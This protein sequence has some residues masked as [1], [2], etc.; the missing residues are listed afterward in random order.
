MA[1]DGK[2]HWPTMPGN[3]TPGHPQIIGSDAFP[4]PGMMDAPGGVPSLGRPSDGMLQTYLRG[5]F[6][7][8]GLPVPYAPAEFSPEKA[9]ANPLYSVPG[10]LAQQRL[11]Y[12]H[13]GAMT[14]PWLNPVVAG[15]VAR[16]EI[17]T[18][19]FD[20]RPELRGSGNNAPTTVIPIFRGPAFGAGGRLLFQIGRLDGGSIQD[21]GV[22]IE[23]YSIEGLHISDD[24]QVVPVTQPQ[25]ITPDFWAGATGVMLEFT[26]PGYPV[27]YWQT[28]LRFDQTNDVIGNAVPLIIWAVCS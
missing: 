18:P 20:F 15:V 27:R 11:G 28:T 16:M 2:S 6:A 5:G 26:P 14:P 25:V 3:F 23:V 19:I 10:P 22:D 9:E 1:K 24:T 13:S 4:L 17:T 8:R 7:Q 21:I 12:W